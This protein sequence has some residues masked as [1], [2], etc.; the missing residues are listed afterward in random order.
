MSNYIK[1]ILNVSK[2]FQDTL[3]IP[4]RIL[5]NF[6]KRLQRYTVNTSYND[7]SSLRSDWERVGN[8]FRKGILVYDR[9]ITKQQR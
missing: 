9:Q 5:F 2:A 7:E 8:D 4:S 6:N 3:S 1:I